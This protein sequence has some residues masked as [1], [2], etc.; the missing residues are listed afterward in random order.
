MRIENIMKNM[1]KEGY[2][3]DY[4]KFGYWDNIPY[5]ENK[6]GH[7]LFLCNMVTD[8]YLNCSTVVENNKE[9]L[10]HIKF[11]IDL[12]FEDECISYKSYNRHR[13]PMYASTYFYEQNCFEENRAYSK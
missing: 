10:D 11:M 2:N 3:C 12:I 5:V 4:G 9:T 7:K 8:T 1:R 6:E 13:F